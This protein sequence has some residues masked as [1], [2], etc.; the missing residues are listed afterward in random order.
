M[1]RS[2]AKIHHWAK[3]IAPSHELRRWYQHDPSKWKAFR[4][5]YFSEL[6]GNPEGLAELR[7]E[8]DHGRVTLVFS[9]RETQLNNATALKEFLETRSD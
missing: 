3:A 5:R 4:K 6:E 8:L 1:S 2:T 9:S 7:G